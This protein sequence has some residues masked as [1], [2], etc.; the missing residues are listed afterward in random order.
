[1]TKVAIILTNYLRPLNVPKQLS[2]LTGARDEFDFI[3]IDNAS[4]PV[5]LRS[6][7]LVEGWYTYIENGDNY[8]AGFRFLLSCGLPYDYII[9]VDDDVF[10]TENQ[11]LTVHEGLVRE[12]SRVHGIW[13]QILT[14]RSPRRR[15][16]GGSSS[17][18]CCVNVIS[19][20]YGYTPQTAFR[21]LGIAQDMGFSCWRDIGPT[22][23][24]LL[25]AASDGFP[26]CHG[27][28]SLA[29]CE[30]S[31]ADNVAT[32]KQRGF[33][34]ARNALI[35]KLVAVGLMRNPSVHADIAKP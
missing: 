11:L 22:D 29:V 25:S 28:D 26:V 27:T 16:T 18:T 30:T 2:L 19:R 34:P 24:I 20:V 13:G 33:Y 12:D 35:D 1:M 3:V 5:N 32:W 21:A 10:L 8:G 31:D 4:R 7:G 23:D 9:A 6:R 17:N 14:E 15:L